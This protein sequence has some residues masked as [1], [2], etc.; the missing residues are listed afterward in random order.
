MSIGFLLGE[1]EALYVSRR[2]VN[3][4]HRLVQG[5]ETYSIFTRKQ[6]FHPEGMTANSRAVERS[7]TPGL[8]AKVER[9]PAGVP[10]RADFTSNHV[11]MVLPLGLTKMDVPKCRFF[12]GDLCSLMLAVEVKSLP[13][14]GPCFCP[15]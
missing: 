14:H 10:L 8:R 5:L 4:S 1:K 9:A 15:E 12:K 2:K 11:E 3:L 13:Q 6:A 7:D